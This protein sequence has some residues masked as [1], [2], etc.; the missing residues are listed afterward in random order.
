MELKDKVTVSVTPSLNK[1]HS[2]RWQM[3]NWKKQYLGELRNYDLA[4]GLEKPTK[5]KLTIIRYGSRLLDID[6]LNGGCKPLIDSI[7]QLCLIWD[8]SPK[9]CEIHI[10]QQLCPRLQEKTEFYIEYENN[11]EG[12]GI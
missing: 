2:N 4:Y 12:G 5:T 3:L 7:K 8:D 1:L 11:K 10:S 9:W 6:N